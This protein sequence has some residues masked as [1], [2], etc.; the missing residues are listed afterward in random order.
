MK[1]E[2]IYKE[3]LKYTEKYAGALRKHFFIV[4]GS[5]MY[6]AFIVM[7]TVFYAPSY[8]ACLNTGGTTWMI[9]NSVVN[10]F[11]V[12]L[13]IFFIFQG[14]LPDKNFLKAF[15]KIVPKALFI[16]MVF[17]ILSYGILFFRCRNLAV[18]KN[19]DDNQRTAFNSLVTKQVNNQ[20]FINNLYIFYQKQMGERSPLSS[21]SNYYN[22]SYQNNDNLNNCSASN[23]GNNVCNVNIDPSIGAPVLAEFFIMT[24]GR[25]CVVNYQYDGYMSSKM[26]KLALLGGA[27]C[28]DF[29]V[30]SLNFSKD[31]T[32]IVTISRDRDNKNLQ[33]NYV[34]LCNLF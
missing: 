19:C 5:C 7:A 12:V 28:L 18:C 24:S 23:I 32:P 15:M 33:H 20:N 3:A 1:G 27:R 21:C 11:F 2:D 16:C 6:I 13:L 14:F 10:A 31:P 34:I 29:D 25:T 22:A 9:V 4:V 8:Y 30:T 26:I 17:L